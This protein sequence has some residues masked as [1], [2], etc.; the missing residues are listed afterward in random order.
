MNIRVT[1]K[2]DG[3]LMTDDRGT[4]RFMTFRETILWY[5]FKR[6]PPRV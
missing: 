2:K 4:T 5:L 6:V 1:K 3:L